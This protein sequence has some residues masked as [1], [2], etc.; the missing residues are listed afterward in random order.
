MQFILTAPPNTNSL[1]FF[2][3]IP[4]NLLRKLSSNM[5]VEKRN[6]KK[7]RKMTVQDYTNSFYLLGASHEILH[8]VTD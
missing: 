8:R 3:A 4:T 5:S 2:H 1:A 7:E 6:Y